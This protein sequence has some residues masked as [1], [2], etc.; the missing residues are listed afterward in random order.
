MKHS[1]LVGSRNPIKIRKLEKLRRPRKVKKS[2]DLQG[3]PPPTV[4]SA[5]NNGKVKTLLELPASWT[6]NTSVRVI[7]RAGVGV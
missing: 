1:L 5:V 2:Q 7:T 6:G 3:C 4:I